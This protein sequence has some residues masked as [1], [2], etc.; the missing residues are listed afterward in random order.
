MLPLGRLPNVHR[1]APYDPRF[2]EDRIGIWVP[3]RG[4]VAQKIQEIMKGH[5]A[6]E[7]HLH[8]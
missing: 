3:C 5:G 8:A 1:R 4:E 7:V 6:E 2:T